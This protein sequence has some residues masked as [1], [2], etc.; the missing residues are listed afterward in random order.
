[1]KTNVN[2][3]RFVLIMILL[4]GM[5]GAI[6]GQNWSNEDPRWHR[7][8]GKIVYEDNKTISIGTSYVGW[9]Y[10]HYNDRSYQENKPQFTVAQIPQLIKIFETADKLYV[11]CSDNVVKLEFKKQIGKIGNF[12]FYFIGGSRNYGHIFIQEVGEDIYDS[13]IFREANETYVEYL[14]K[15]RDDYYRKVQAYDA[16]LKISKSKTDTEIDNIIKNK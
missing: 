15:Y 7:Q 12:V 9:Y 2:V 10:T 13:V 6:Y 5:L 11:Y 4:S 14:T 3:T 8:N 16:K 1:M